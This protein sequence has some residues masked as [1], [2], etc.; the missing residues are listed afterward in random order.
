[1]VSNVCFVPEAR[2][3]IAILTNN[4]N[5]SFFE[6]LRYQLLDAFLEVPFVNRSKL[7]LKPFNDGEKQTLDTIAAWRARVTANAPAQGMQ[8]Y[9]GKYSNP[10]YG[11]ITMKATGAGQLEVK[12]EHHPN[13]TGKLAYMGQNDWLLEFNNIEYGIF[14]VAFVPEGN[15]VKAFELKVND[16][17]EYGTYLFAKE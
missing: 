17:V 13:L 1:M 9:S 12:F 14:K 4:D 10:L 11:H 2:L 5:Q 15:S 6:A 16:F 8:A 7:M 3:G